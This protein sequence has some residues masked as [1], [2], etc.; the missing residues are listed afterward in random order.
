MRLR[1]IFCADAFI[2]SFI[3][4]SPIGQDMLDLA[5][6]FKDCYFFIK[7]SKGIAHLLVGLVRNSLVPG[8]HDEDA[9]VQGMEKRISLD[10]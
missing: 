8:L 6:A 7:K 9:L 10:F 3:V 5:S 2:F 4:L 1:R